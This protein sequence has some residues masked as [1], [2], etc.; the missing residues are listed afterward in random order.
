MY[1]TARVQHSAA[2]SAV[3][4]PVTLTLTPAHRGRRINGLEGKARMAALLA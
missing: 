1:L 3:G 4:T 2:S